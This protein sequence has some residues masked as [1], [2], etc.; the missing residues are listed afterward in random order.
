[1]RD[2]AAWRR[3]IDISKLCCSMNMLK[4]GDVVNESPCCIVASV[5]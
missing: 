4:D 3:E 5:A 2:D 1:M